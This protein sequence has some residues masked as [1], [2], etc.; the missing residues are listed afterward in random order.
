M[1]GKDRVKAMNT[2][3]ATDP[4]ERSPVER[5]VMRKADCHINCHDCGQLLKKHLWVPKDHRWKKHALC[6][7]CLS[8]Y[9]DPDI[10]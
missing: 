4:R 3:I 6:L 7:D 8:N 5:G 9:D 2:R 10:Y 1:S